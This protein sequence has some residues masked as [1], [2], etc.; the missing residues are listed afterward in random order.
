MQVSDT[1]SSIHVMECVVYTRSLWTK[2]YYTLHIAISYTCIM[3]HACNVYASGCA[4]S[5]SPSHATPM[6]DDEQDIDLS[7]H[8]HPCLAVGHLSVFSG[9]S[10]EF[11][12]VGPQRGPVKVCFSTPKLGGSG[13][14]P[15]QEIFENQLLREQFWC[16]LGSILSQN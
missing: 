3:H 12:L 4:L 15:P 6:S 13:G 2:K 16:I 7:E 11:M 1:Y 10:R 9:V 14:M 5:S 8:N